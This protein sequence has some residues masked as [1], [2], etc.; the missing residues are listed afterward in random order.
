MNAEEGGGRRWGEGE[1][2]AGSRSVG[3]GKDSRTAGEKVN[4]ERHNK[5]GVEGGAEVKG[6]E[7]NPVLV[8]FCCIN[9]VLL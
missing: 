2:E 8:L 4:G 3:G 9:F 1:R 5:R 6:D 7:K